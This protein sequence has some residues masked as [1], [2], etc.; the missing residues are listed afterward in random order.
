M[1]HQVQ[2]F[3]SLP[4]LR[5]VLLYPFQQAV[6]SLMEVTSFFDCNCSKACQA[7]VMLAHKAILSQPINFSSLIYY[8]HMRVHILFSSPVSLSFV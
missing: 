6:H 8:Q 4:S 5:T 1:Q 2:Y 7:L 3:P